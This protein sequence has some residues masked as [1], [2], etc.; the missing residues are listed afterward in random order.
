MTV[1]FRQSHG[2]ADTRVSFASVVSLHGCCSSLSLVSRMMFVEV[3]RCPLPIIQC[4]F[5][6]E[7][8]H[9]TGHFY[10]L[11][12]KIVI[13]PYSVSFNISIYFHLSINMY[14]YIYIMFIYL[15]ICD[16][17]HI[18]KHTY[19]YIRLTLYES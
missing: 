10:L 18:H 19:I 12:V 11:I 8:S 4:S 2:T 6:L 9:S 14:I 13:P 5:L 7:T 16:R 15:N 3:G 17:L 1:S